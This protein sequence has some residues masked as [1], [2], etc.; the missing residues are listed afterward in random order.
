[1]FSPC[2]AGSRLG[3]PVHERR[4]H[5]L[6]AIRVAIDD[7]SGSFSKGAL[8]HR[9]GRHLLQASKCGLLP[10]LVRA[11]PAQLFVMVCFDDF[12]RQARA[13]KAEYRA[14]ASVAFGEGLVEHSH[15][16]TVE[17]H[18][19]C[20]VRR[21]GP[22]DANPS[23]QCVVRRRFSLSTA[24]PFR[25]GCTSAG[26]YSQFCCGFSGSVQF[27]AQRQP[28][29]TLRDPSDAT[30]RP[31]PTPNACRWKYVPAVQACISGHRRGAPRRKPGNTMR[32]RSCRW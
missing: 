1:M 4:K 24:T 10:P 8:F 15:Q 2:G 20:Q 29:A 16:I 18:C 19:L 14:V 22:I 17:P 28:P 7:G 32:R 30:R 25:R 11:I 21:A 3:S 31:A 27:I 5:N 23:G 6:A 26:R 12:Q 13:G 9:L